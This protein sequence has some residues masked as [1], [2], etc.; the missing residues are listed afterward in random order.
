MK[1]EREKERRARDNSGKDRDV[2]GPLASDALLG[3]AAREAGMAHGALRG[4][5]IPAGT[6]DI[7]DGRQ[8]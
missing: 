5:R 2:C 1:K 3:R 7:P 4:S 6:S 8:P